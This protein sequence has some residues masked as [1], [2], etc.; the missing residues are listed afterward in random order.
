MSSGGAHFR[1][2]GS[3][4]ELRP[5]PACYDSG[6]KWSGNV[7]DMSG[8]T[9]SMG[10]DFFRLARRSTLPSPNA[11]RTAVLCAA[12]CASPRTVSHPPAAATPAASCPGAARHLTHLYRPQ[13]K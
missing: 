8:K 1:A 3:A 12:P 11:A 5:C 4:A 9:G 13:L 10:S 6:V 7:S 2:A